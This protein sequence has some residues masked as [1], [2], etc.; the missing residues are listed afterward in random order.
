MFPSIWKEVSCKVVFLTWLAFARCSA[1]HMPASVS[2]IQTEAQELLLYVGFSLVTFLLCQTVSK[3][4]QCVFV[5]RTALTLTA[6][7][8]QLYY[9]LSWAFLLYHE[10]KVFRHL[11]CELIQFCFAKGSEGCFEGGGTSVWIVLERPWQQ[12][13]LKVEANSGLIHETLLLFVRSF[14]C[15]RWIFNFFCQ[16]M[17][18]TKPLSSVWVFWVSPFL[19]PLA[20]M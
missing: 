17:T 7:C 13:N 12:Q 1:R 15:Y 4:N 11:W 8:S 3:P 14:P 20:Y 10:S 18:L 2:N 5:C 9:V 19:P 6:K 16:S